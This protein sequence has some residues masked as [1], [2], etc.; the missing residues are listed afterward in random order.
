MLALTIREK[1]G[2][3]RQLIF[4]KEEV[5]IGRATGSDIVLPRSNISKRHARLVDKHDKVVIVDLRSTNGTYVNGRRITAPELLTY[6]DKVYIGDFVIRLS[7][8]AEQHPSQKMTTPYSAS[9]TPAEP[10]AARAATAAVDP[11]MPPPLD[12]DDSDFGTY[13]EEPAALPAAS[14]HPA[15]HQPHQPHQPDDDESTRAIAAFEDDDFPEPP[16]KPEPPKKAPPKVEPPVPLPPTGKKEFVAAPAKPKL[17]VPQAP[18]APPTP[19][20]PIAATPPKPPALAARPS[21]PPTDEPAAISVAPLPSHRP[22][23]PPEP[24]FDE[25]MTGDG[26]MPKGI[27]DDLRGDVSD[28]PWAEWNAAI[29]VVVTEIENSHPDGFDDP[30]G[31]AAHGVDRAIS[32]GLIA[33]ET[34]RDALT[35]DVVAELA[36]TGPL[37]ELLDDPSV[38]LV[39]LNGPK[40]VFVGRGTAPAP[41]EPNGRL[42]ATSRSYRRALASLSGRAEDVISD[43][44]GSDE[45]RLGDGSVLRIVGSGSAT[46]LAVWHRAAIDVPLL[47][48]LVAEGILEESQ[49]QVIGQALAARRNVVICGLATGGRA[50]VAAAIAAEIGL[51]RRVAVVGDGSRLALAQAD[52]ARIASS[53]L[54]SA[55]HLASLEADLVIFERLDGSVITDW[56][57]ASLIGGAPVLTILTEANPDRALKRLGLALELASGVEGRGLAVVGECVDLVVSLGATGDGSTKVDKVQDVE[58]LKDGFALK[59]PARR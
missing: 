42:F 40:A 16:P 13:D 34:D 20:A 23:P 6:E 49:A 12:G 43:L 44:M 17:P 14:H 3:E 2:E 7:R 56:A 18:V 8:P 41:L 38:R 51:D 48:D 32:M 10:R 35:Q 50:A 53:A 45:H 29:E 1:N 58:P 31:L 47:P 9:A 26:P 57:E 19:P 28:D 21:R 22:P 37:V 46:P 52:V 54:M 11:H 15:P 55:G 24:D 5:T 33:P 4:E 30:Q 27:E 39:A 36:G 25:E 59:A